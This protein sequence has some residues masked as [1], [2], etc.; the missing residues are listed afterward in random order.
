MQPSDPKV[1]IAIVEDIS[2]QKEAT[3]TQ[4]LLLKK[5]V[6]AEEEE[7]KR[8]ARELHDETGQTLTSLLVG[9]RSLE[10]VNNLQEVKSIGTGLRQLT[11][12][13][14]EEV[15]RLSQ[16]LHPSILD[17]LGLKAAIRWLVREV[18]AKHGLQIK[19]MSSSVD[20][21]RFDSSIEL[22]LYR[23]IQE[24]LTNIAKHART[25]KGKV[26]F[27]HQHNFIKTVIEDNGCG[28][29]TQTLSTHSES[30]KNLG[31]L[32]IRE[33]VKILDG[34]FSI[35][36]TLTKGTTISIEIPF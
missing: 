12:R 22:T 9:L 32:G 4:A 29:N 33:R 34:T 30:R 28:F 27:E 31:L 18:N 15:R 26:I 19:L 36:S 35:Q 10:E 25:K 24:G 6:N 7:R 17:D 2:Q 1:H 5:A 3:Q 21:E 8:I 13:T 14:I 20:S 23:I 16:G 11:S